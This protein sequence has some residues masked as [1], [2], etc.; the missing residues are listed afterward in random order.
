MGS[1]SNFGTENELLS[2]MCVVSRFYGSFCIVSAHAA[3]L[4]EGHNP[5]L[6]LT[7]AGFRMLNHSHSKV[8][9]YSSPSKRIKKYRFDFFFFHKLLLNIQLCHTFLMT[10]DI[11]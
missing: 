11:V 6:E 2:S 3:S 8:T 4:F 9:K 10:D 1:H 5:K 7:F